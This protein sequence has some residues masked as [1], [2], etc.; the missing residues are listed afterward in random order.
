MMMLRQ[1]RIRLVVDV[2]RDS[3]CGCVCV[4]LRKSG[5]FR[6]M[7]FSGDTDSVSVHDD[8]YDT[9]IFVMSL[10]DHHHHTDDHGYTGLCDS[11]HA[12]VDLWSC[13]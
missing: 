7:V 4:F 13:C 1:K 6:F 10:Y 12:A 8:Y 2:V 5:L 9:Y 11:G 3:A